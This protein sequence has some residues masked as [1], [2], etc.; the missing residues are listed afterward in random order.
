MHEREPILLLEARQS[1]IL[2]ALVHW[3]YEKHNEAAI[4]AEVPA[5]PEI[6]TDLLDVASDLFDRQMGL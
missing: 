2:A 1:A 6:A 5:T 3:P 4:L